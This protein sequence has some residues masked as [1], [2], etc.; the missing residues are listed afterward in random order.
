MGRSRAAYERAL[1]LDPD[2][3]ASSTNLALLEA[4]AGELDA[5]LARLDGVLARH[6]EADGAVAQRKGDLAGAVRDI[7]AAHA[8][9]PDAALA[10]ALANLYGAAGDTTRAETWGREARR[11]DPRQ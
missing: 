9:R 2:L 3:A 7:E 6:P 1:A 4:D 5:A 11:L 10:A 8:I